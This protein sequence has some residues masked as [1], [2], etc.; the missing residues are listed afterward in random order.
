MW[1]LWP[2]V[3]TANSFLY[4]F[5]YTYTYTHTHFLFRP[6]VP[7]WPNQIGLHSHTLNLIDYSSL[8]ANFISFIFLPP[9]L[10]ALVDDTN[11]NCYT[12]LTHTH[13]EKKREET[14]STVTLQSETL[15]FSF[16]SSFSTCVT[17]RDHFLAS[18]SEKKR[19]RSRHYVQ[20]PFTPRHRD[21][22]V[23]NRKER[24]LRSIFLY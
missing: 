1:A 7:S 20:V 5:S 2:Q 21:T 24:K 9:F 11:C 8:I 13:K 6:T 17:L 16:S 4:F 12:H 19:A 22:I 23:T 3:A 18:W 14:A 10:H 15:S